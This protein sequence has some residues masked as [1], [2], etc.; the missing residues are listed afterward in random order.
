M[1]SNNPFRTPTVT[2]MPTGASTFSSPGYFPPPQGPPP[3][4]LLTSNTGGGFQAPVRSGSES[5]VD[6]G[7]P[8]QLP[9]LA[10]RPS[11]TRPG[12]TPVAPPLP[13]RVST[14]SVTSRV[15]S[16]GPPSGT[17]PPLPSRIN[18]PSRLDSLGPP[19]GTPPPL[20]SR[21]TVSSPTN[22]S[23]DLPTNTPPTD[24]A[25]PP[26][27]TPTPDAFIG[28]STVDIGPRRPFQPAPQPAPP[29]HPA[30][31]WGPPAPPANNWAPPPQAP[32]NN[33]GSPSP[34]AN[35]WIPPPQA[36]S[37]LRA[38]S[39]DIRSQSQP[40]SPQA[41]LSDF[42]RE[43]YSA[44]AGTPGQDA[45]QAR[46]APPPGE[47]P[48]RPSSAA[49]SS[50][51][52]GG[53][54]GSGSGPSNDGRPTSTPT[55]GHPLLNKGRILVYPQGY[56]CDKCLNTGYKSYDPTHPCRKD[57]ERYGRTYTAIFDSSPWGPNASQGNRTKWSF[58]KPL[59]DL[60]GPPQASTSAS[61]SYLTP[62]GTAHRRSVSQPQ[63]PPP[64][65][66]APSRPV[67]VLPGM[68]PPPGATVV[69]PGDPRIGGQL[70]WRCGGRG[71]TPFLIFDELPCETCGGVG[72][73][74]P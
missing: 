60:R 2:P 40:I 64:L 47:P 62:P 45:P 36:S 43:F 28:E 5:P 14:S 15:D 63:G 35:N 52:H 30:N 29:V 54:G 48:R 69:M 51:R 27:Y 25:P 65:N 12:P 61:S 58:Q 72:R 37:S 31:N 49:G 9:G 67:A 39:P 7:P 17:P 57:W 23:F 59:P 46:F 32:P 70:C 53:G 21:I 16:L 3:P 33:W 18:A 20:P 24:D 10:P 38:S 68:R 42:A 74:F 1:A 66:R 55:P 22:Q 26:A 50:T 13:P 8:E 41:D 56:T 11:L 71:M 44:G 19:S 73:V 4:H 6:D 34:P